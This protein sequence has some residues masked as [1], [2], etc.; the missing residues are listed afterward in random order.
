[1]T[2]EYATTEE[3]CRHFGRKRET[4]RRWREDLGFPQP[5]HHGHAR[6]PCRFV[7]AEVLAW[8]AKYRSLRNTLPQAP[9]EHEGAPLDAG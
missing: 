3:V 7:I 1:M 9:S 6:G 4:I 8:D 5:V 2:K